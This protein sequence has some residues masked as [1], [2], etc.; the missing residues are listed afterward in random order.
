MNQNGIHCPYRYKIVSLDFTAGVQNQYHQTFTFR[1]KMWMRRDMR[2]PVVGGLCRRL[3]GLH[4][5]RCGTFLEGY[6]LPLLRLGWKFEWFD[7][8]VRRLRRWIDGICRVHV[9]AFR[10]E[11]TDCSLHRTG[12]SNPVPNEAHRACWPRC[13]AAERKQCSAT[14]YFVARNCRTATRSAASR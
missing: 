6:N 5:F 12:E 9:F 3:T 1:I 13:R 2:P 14:T 4:G 8:L 7:D 10:F 11:G